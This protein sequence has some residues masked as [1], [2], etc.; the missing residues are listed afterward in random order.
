M[1][2]KRV[3][4]KLARVSFV[5]RLSL[6]GDANILF[7]VVCLLSL[8]VPGVGSWSARWAS[9]LL[10]RL[11]CDHSCSF[12]WS[13]FLQP[14]VPRAMALDN[15]KRDASMT[16][17][18][19]APHLVDMDDPGPT[20]PMNRDVLA[21][22][23]K[24]CLEPDS[25]TNSSDLEGFEPAALEEI[26]VD[27]TLLKEEFEGHAS[28]K[29]PNFAKVQHHVA[30]QLPDA[31]LAVDTSPSNRRTFTRPRATPSTIILMTPP[32]RCQELSERRPG[33]ALVRRT[34]GQ[35]TCGLQDHCCGSFLRPRITRLHGCQKL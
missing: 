23:V 20:Q 34:K 27:P 1:S 13:C 6:C 25:T 4:C 22:G 30:Q 12:P 31:H 18:A 32:C 35:G 24:R 29:M 28:W 14:L 7:L 11:C 26:A 17:T 16:L 15:D 9:C 5:L 10:C 21:R 8:C 2:L 33:Q 3:G 19:E